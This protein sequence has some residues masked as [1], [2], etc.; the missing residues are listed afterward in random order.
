[1]RQ[2]D[3]ARK[4]PMSR[5]W[6]R[7]PSI[8]KMTV[9]MDR[10]FV[11]PEDPEDWTPY[12]PCPSLHLVSGITAAAILALAYIFEVFFSRKSGESQRRSRCFGLDAR[13][14]SAFPQI[15]TRPVQVGSGVRG[16]GAEEHAAECC[17]RWP[18]RQRDTSRA[19]GAVT[20][21]RG[22]MEAVIVGRGRMGIDEATRIGRSTELSGGD[23]DT[24]ESMMGWSRMGHR[25]RRSD[26]TGDS[27]EVVYY[28][29]TEHGREGMDGVHLVFS[30]IKPHIW[31]SRFALFK[32]GLIKACSVVPQGLHETELKKAFYSQ[33]LSSQSLD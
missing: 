23:Y 30:P 13:A 9:E 31:T 3:P 11:W 28:D 26:S 16:K 5:R 1:M 4:R 12:V 27:R 10:P 6:Y 21:R 20:P 17:L 7:G 22:A 8:K 19:S 32:N 25:A 29:C 14:N 24:I 33:T 15:W 18:G 2:D